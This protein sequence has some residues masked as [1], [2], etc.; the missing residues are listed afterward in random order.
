MTVFPLFPCQQSWAKSLKGLQGMGLQDSGSVSG[1][2]RAVTPANVT[3]WTGE[4]S[5]SLLSF[6]LYL[7][8]FWEQWVEGGGYEPDELGCGEQRHI[9]RAARPSYLSPNNVPWKEGSETALS[10]W[11]PS[12][13]GTEVQ[14]RLH[15]QLVRRNPGTGQRRNRLTG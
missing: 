14:G 11:H 9:L 2:H 1:L 13:E 15:T 4:F 3:S 10:K 12:K 5:V 6:I 8:T 7:G